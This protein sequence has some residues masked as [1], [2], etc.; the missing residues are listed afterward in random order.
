MQKL[1]CAVKTEKTNWEELLTKKIK[2]LPHKKENFGYKIS[3]LFFR[4]WNYK[5]SYQI[6]KYVNLK[7][8]LFSYKWYQKNKKQY[9]TAKVLLM[10]WTFYFLVM[11]YVLWVIT[12]IISFFRRKTVFACLPFCKTETTHTGILQ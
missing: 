11:V 6:W 3:Y 9:F 7:Q 4:Y 1:F 5:K 12:V 10:W 2:F 8:E